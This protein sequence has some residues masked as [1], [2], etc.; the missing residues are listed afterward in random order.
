MPSCS[1]EGPLEIGEQLANDTLT[2]CRR[3][4][5][6]RYAWKVSS[7]SPS[8]PVPGCYTNQAAH[9]AD[10]ITRNHHE[11]TPSSKCRSG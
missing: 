5:L 8:S 11:V 3:T 4:F 2:R 10:V 1:R 9:I 6:C 7:P